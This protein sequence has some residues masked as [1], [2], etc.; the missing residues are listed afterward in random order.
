MSKYN[1]DQ[2]IERRGTDSIKWSQYPE[3]VIPMWVADSDF[4]APDPVIKALSARVAHPAYGYA[5]DNSK[6]IIDK[7]ARHWMKSRFGWNVPEGHS[8]FAPGVITSICLAVQ[9]F[10]QAGENVLTLSPAYPPITHRPRQNGRNS[11][12]SPLVL[13]EDGHYSIDFNDLEAKLALRETSLFI[14][15]NP[16][17]P[18]GR[19]FSRDELQKIAE[20]CLANNVII[21]S[22]EIHCDYIHSG[23]HIPLPTLS[24]AVAASCLVTINPSKTFNTAGMHSASV[25]SENA[26]LLARYRKASEAAGVHAN[27]LG[28][29]AFHAA[30]MECADYAD[31]VSAYVRG[32]LEYA[33]SFINAEIPGLRAAMPEASYLLW[34]DC[35]GLGLAPDKLVE[36]FIDR[37]KVAPSPGRNYNSHGG[38]EGD[39]FIRLNLACP[40]ATVEKALERIKQA[41]QGK[42][43]KNC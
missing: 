6:P 32:N 21:L 41:V 38:S 29:A 20:L 40:R 22:D 2:I 35:R 23:R 18:T 12:A 36:L 24:P 30:Y 37:A 28:V 15:C 31:E 33:S 16:H 13:G 43:I 8:V 7:A 39:G 9:A 27:I 25:L 14:L 5:D 34:V 1:F 10:T 11:L 19:V 26:E 3:D 4:A 42:M 17:N